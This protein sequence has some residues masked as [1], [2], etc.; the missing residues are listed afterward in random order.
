[1]GPG[2]PFSLSAPSQPAS[3][4]RQPQ[5]SVRAHEP[6]RAPALSPVGS[7]QPEGASHRPLEGGGALPA[8]LT[9][10]LLVGMSAG[11]GLG[12]VSAFGSW[13]QVL[14]VLGFVVVGGLVAG[15]GF[16][17]RAG[18]LNFAGA[19]RALWSR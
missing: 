8:G 3:P 13:S 12:V 9:R 6:E 10:A 16:G 17:V 18:L 1:M 14:V 11:F 4:P 5:P 7:W 19:W 2:D 15:V